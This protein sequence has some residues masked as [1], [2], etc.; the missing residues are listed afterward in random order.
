V[1]IA[2]ASQSGGTPTG[3][4]VG[5]TNLTYQQVLDFPTTPSRVLRF[6]AASEPTGSDTLQSITSLLVALP[7]R[8]AARAAVFR[9]L[10]QLPGVRYLGPARDP[11]GRAGVAVTFNNSGPTISTGVM[12]TAAPELREE[13]IF[14]PQ[15]A[16]LLA[17]ETLLL[18]PPHIPGLPSP[19]ATNWT[20]YTSSRAVPQ[21]TTPTS[22]QLG[23]NPSHTPPPVRLPQGRTITTTTTT[24]AT[25]TTT[26]TEPR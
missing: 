6:I 12:N 4:S 8:P 15:T 7:L 2:T 26:V 25:T 3:F 1:Q 22:T 9:A 13:L 20:A 10:I 5:N 21:A 23:L 17:Q 24:V 16:A 14:D 19:L 11:L 18:N